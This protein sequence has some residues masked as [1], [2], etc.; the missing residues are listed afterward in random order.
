MSR[1]ATRNPGQA[2][3]FDVAIVGGGPAGSAAGFLLASSGANVCIVERSSFPRYKV[4]GGAL[5][6]RS[7]KAL[8]SSGLLDERELEGQTVLVERTLAC[9]DG[10]RRLRS[11]TTSGPGIRMIDRTAFDALLLEKARAA[12]ACVIE[13][14]AVTS[15]VRRDGGFRLVLR[16][17]DEPLSSEFLVGADGAASTVRRQLTR[18]RGVGVLPAVGLQIRVP[19]ER[20]ESGAIPEEL[21]IHFGLLPYGYGW[22]FPGRDNVLIGIGGVERRRH[23]ALR[24]RSA[25]L[26]LAGETGVTEPGAEALEGA[27]ITL[28]GLEPSLGSGRVFL[29]GDAGGLVDRVSGEGIGSAIES[30]LLSA[31]MILEGGDRNGV[32][33]KRAGAPNGCLRR[34]RESRLCSHL[35][36]HPLLRRRA[37]RRLA[38]TDKFY[39]GYWDLLSGSVGYAGLMRRFLRRTE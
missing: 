4:C 7:C 27:V 2:K 30:G 29:A 25:L 14:E 32:S 12:G 36:Y 33:G 37:M 23:S 11:F 21:R 19:R 9:F 16:Q 34:A 28:C 39:R 38:E 35:L 24:V 31:G 22:V 18:R 5:S 1:H 6:E 10:L 26:S 20:L 15:V 3:T 13:G 17:R 8:L